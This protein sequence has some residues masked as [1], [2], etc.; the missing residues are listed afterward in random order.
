VTEIDQRQARHGVCFCSQAG[1]A[2][3]RSA[4]PNGDLGQGRYA[5]CAPRLLRKIL[6]SLRPTRQ[7][8]RGKRRPANG[9]VLSARNAERSQTPDQWVP[10]PSDRKWPTRGADALGPSI[11]VVTPSWAACGEESLNQMWSSQQ[12]RVLFPFF[13]FSIFLSPYF[14]FQFCFS[15]NSNQ[16]KF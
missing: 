7:W 10:R 3:V 12:N 8:H 15:S 5:I 4:G 11:S 2:V 6:S 13:F 16:T 14:F 1:W 9:P